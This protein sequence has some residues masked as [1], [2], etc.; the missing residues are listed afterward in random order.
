MDQRFASRANAPQQAARRGFR[1]V[2]SHVAGRALWRPT[3]QA[4]EFARTAG[5]LVR[6]A[7]LEERA[8]VLAV[9]EVRAFIV[10]HRESSRDPSAN[11]V[12]VRAQDGGCFAYGVG[13][14]CLA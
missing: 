2:V 6:F 11:R 8:N 14:T 4:I 12:L 1:D 13:L 5:L 10:S 3:A 7:C 9:D